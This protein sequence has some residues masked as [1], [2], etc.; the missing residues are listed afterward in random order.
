MNIKRTKRGT[1]HRKGD[2]WY[3][4]EEGSDE[5]NLLWYTIELFMHNSSETDEGALYYRGANIGI[6]I[7]DLYS[8]HVDETWSFTPDPE[9]RLSM[10]DSTVYAKGLE[11]LMDKVLHNIEG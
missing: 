3:C 5:I 6:V 4:K 1:W 7:R 2:A 10:D 9:H 11:E 8:E